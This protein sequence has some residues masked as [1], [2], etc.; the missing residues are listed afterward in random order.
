[1]NPDD[2]VM[3]DLME[4]YFDLAG[5]PVG[6]EVLEHGLVEG[7]WRGNVGAAT[8][9]ERTSRAVRCV[10]ETRLGARRAS[11][12]AAKGRRKNQ[13]LIATTAA[14]RVPEVALMSV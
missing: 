12:D 13:C 14:A 3:D 9:A 11:G 4:R 1:M 2:P 7:G 6:G 5:M 10:G 8:L